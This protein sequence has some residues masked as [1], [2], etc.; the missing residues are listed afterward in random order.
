M[1]D[2]ISSVSSI[3]G[4]IQT[5]LP[6]VFKS[7]F[8]QFEKAILANSAFLKEG[9]LTVISTRLSTLLQ[10]WVDHSVFPL[11][12][13]TLLNEL[14]VVSES[15]FED[16]Y[17]QM[18][19]KRMKEAFKEAL[20]S[21]QKKVTQTF[22]EQ[23]TRVITQGSVKKSFESKKD[24]SLSEL[25]KDLDALIIPSSPL[26]RSPVLSLPSVPSAPIYVQETSSV[27]KESPILV[28]D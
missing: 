21:M 1:S 9:S 27:R 26:P 6:S 10:E 22:K 15:V 16:M 12:S 3:M 13:R 20:V 5:Q 2:E 24:L 4:G 8:E 19:K 28:M 14:S 25:R 17:H 7:A 23:W 11:V 18:D